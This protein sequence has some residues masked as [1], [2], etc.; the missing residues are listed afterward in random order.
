MPIEAGAGREWQIRTHADEHAAPPLVIDVEVIL[1][2]PALRELQMPA[3]LLLVSDGD[4]DAGW[5]ATFH[6]CH[7]PVRLRI[8]ETGIGEFVAPVFRRLRNR[9]A[10]LLRAVHDPGR[11]W[12]ATSCNTSRLTGYRRRQELRKPITRSGC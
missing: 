7:Y 9:R 12:L 11:N 8:P 1:Y 10:P 4:H 2:D 5:L 6:H 3:I